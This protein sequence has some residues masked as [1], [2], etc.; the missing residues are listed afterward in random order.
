MAGEVEQSK[1]RAGAR[2]AKLWLDRTTRVQASFLNP[3]G[4]AVHK[5]TVK[6][7]NPKGNSKSF[8]FDLGGFMRG[9]EFKGQGF[10]AEC[11]NYKNESDLP[12]HYRAFL[13]HCYRARA[14]NHFLADHF[15][16]I[17][18]SPHQS[19]AWDTHTTVESIQ[20]A[21]MHSDLVD[22]NFLEDEDPKAEFS[23]E[24]AKEVS[25][26][27]WIIVLSDKQVDNLMLTRDHFALIESEM[28]RNGV[29]F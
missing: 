27:L 21:V 19:R 6:K 25:D 2:R 10:L 18:F 13:A 28:I 24:V 11:K 8:S 1:G 5:L 7:A 15:F 16:W 4:V 22:V 3:D 12:A 9:E 26:N 17:S 29:D 14:T 23:A 20:R